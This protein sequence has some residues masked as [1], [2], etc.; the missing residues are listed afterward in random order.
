MIIRTVSSIFQFFQLPKHLCS[1]VLDAFDSFLLGVF[2]SHIDAY[3]KQ[4]I[5]AAYNQNRSKNETFYYARSLK[6]YDN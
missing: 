5:S 6:V 4:F 3:R 2:H 1:L